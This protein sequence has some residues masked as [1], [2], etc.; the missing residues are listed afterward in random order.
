MIIEPSNS[1]Q[2]T[3]TD[4][5]FYYI[6]HG[7]LEGGYALLKEQEID[8]SIKNNLG[9]TP[10]LLAVKLNNLS[11]TSLLLEF[12]ANPNDKNI[13]SLGK[14][15]GLTIASENNYY[16]VASVLLDYGADPNYINFT[17]LGCMHLAAK[18]GYLSLVILLLSRGGDPNLRDKYGNT[19][20]YLAST[21][22]HF[23]ILEILP[24]PQNVKPEDLYEYKQ[25]VMIQSMGYNEDDIKKY[26]AKLA[27]DLKT[28]GKK[29]K[30]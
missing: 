7:N 12:G 2:S 19:P 25:Q 22:N 17:G 8:L 27:K 30:K 29:K 6:N 21:N 3:A 13:N 15:S 28:A 11:Y 5:L 10:L 14:D 26:Q 16:E 20:S 1:I 23:E 18:N 24:P 9:M 4:I